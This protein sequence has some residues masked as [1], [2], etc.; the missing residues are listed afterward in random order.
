MEITF[1]ELLNEWLLSQKD[2]LKQGSYYSYHSRI[3]SMISPILGDR[4][5]CEMTGDD[6]TDLTSEL[7]EKGLSAKTIKLAI[8]VVR[9]AVL[10]GAERYGMEKIVP[11]ELELPQQKKSEHEPLTASE[12]RVLAKFIIAHPIRRNLCILLALTTGVKV[13]ELCG[14][15]WKDL[16]FERNSVCIRQIVY[17]TSRSSSEEK[18]TSIVIQKC[19][20]PREI[21]VP[22]LLMCEFSKLHNNSP[23]DYLYSGEGIPVEPRIAST[24]LKKLLLQCEVHNVSFNDL[25]CT[26]V[27]NCID[28][29]GG[30]MTVAMMLGTNSLNKLLEDFDWKPVEFEKA[31]ELVECV[32]EKMILTVCQTKK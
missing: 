5:I 16:N 32:G 15:Q 24:H 31:S 12:Q 4:N 17:R 2:I 27:Q 14:I 13:G 8:T 10:Y 21:P 22:A 20:D 3:T 26:F 11:N 19:D 29:G 30:I 18:I 6:I 9:N 1:S 28:S 23:D 25:R 7:Q